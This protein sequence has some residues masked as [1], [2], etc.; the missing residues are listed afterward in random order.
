MKSFK[1]LAVAAASALL[2]VSGGVTSAAP[3]F[4][5]DPTVLP[6]G[7]D[8]N[9]A[10]LA[11]TLA[12]FQADFISGTTSELLHLTAT[13]NYGQGWAQF[14]GF[15]NQGPNVSPLVSGINVDYGLYLEFAL[16]VTLTGGVNGFAGS[17]YKVDSLTFAVKADINN[18]NTYTTANALLAREAT[19][20]NTSDDIALAF[21]QLIT[22]VSGIDALGGAFLNSVQSFAVCTGFG[23]AMVGSTVTAAPCAS[24]LGSAFFA[25]PQPFYELAFDAFNNTTQGVTR[26]FG[27]ILPEPT[28][29]LV[30]ISNAIGGVDFN[31][32]PEPGSMALMGIALVGLGLTSRRK[33]V[34]TK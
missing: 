2:L 19:V 23:T 13:G 30:G 10:T 12:P 17:S 31:R 9:P 29:R 15:A 20:G 34:V 4:T 32:V 5:I 6:L 27:G 18:D 24:G 1:R 28:E 21:G 11:H 8:V 25:A 22:G 16:A 26:N 14:T 7:T 3:L 33:G